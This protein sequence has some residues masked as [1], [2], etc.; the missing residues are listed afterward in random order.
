MLEK[1]SRRFKIK[2]ETFEFLEDYAYKNNIPYASVSTALDKIVDEYKERNDNE[3]KL[4][5][6]INQVADEVT[7]SVQVAIKESIS[8]ELRKVRLGTNN[9][10]RNTQILIELVQGYMQSQNVSHILTTDMNPPPFLEKTKDL[11][12][13]RITK[14]KQK[15]D[16][17]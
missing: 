3:F 5:Y 17:K 13:E 7:K 14:Q 6:V 8:D 16:S 1:T 4:N 15:K 9:V 10:D 2:N 12:Q 11:V